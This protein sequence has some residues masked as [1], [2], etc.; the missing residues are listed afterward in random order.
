MRKP[1]FLSTMLLAVW[2]TS[3]CEAPV[4]PAPSTE[5]P[6]AEAPTASPALTASNCTALTT[7]QVSA[8][9]DDGAGSVAANSQDDD[10][11]TRWSGPG[12]GA[13]LTM[14]LGSAQSL[15]GV[16][17]AWHQGTTRQNH[18]TLSTSPDGVTFTQDYAATS[19]LSSAVQ[20]Y[21]FSAPRTGRYVRITVNGNTVNDW[22]SITEA[23]VC[24]VQPVSSVDVGPALPRL[25]YLQSVGP[26]SA[27]VAFRSG[28]S[29]TPYVRFG[30]G[31]D[32]SRTAM[33][34]A[35]GWRHAVKLDNLSPGQTYS[36]SVEACG[37]TT[38]VRQFRTASGAGTSRVHFTAMGDFGTGG[39]L[40]SQVLARMAQGSNA[41]ELILALGD[42]AYSSGTEQEFQDRMFKPMA[43]LLRRVPLF[44][45][46][47]NHEYVT[48]Q[49][50]PYLDNLYMP[51]NN[52]AGSERY[53]SFDWGPVH[54]ISLDSNC[55]IGLASPSRCTLAA[56]KSWV[57]QDLAATGRP[58]KVV[59]FHHP[60][61]S[62]GEHGSQLTMRREFAPLFEQ[63]GVDLVLTG[64]DHN[65]ERSKA[66]KGDG[67][68][69]PGVKGIPYVVVGSG[70]ATLRAFPGAQP[71]WTAYRNNTDAGYLSVV[72]EGGT[73]SAQFINPS[74]TVRDSLSLTKTVPAASALLLSPASSVETPPG[75]VDDP[76]HAPASLRFEH[77]LPPADRPEDVAD[78]G[79]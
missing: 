41:G 60:P 3:A 62:S 47:G 27:L 7:A 31:L 28:V 39:N 46:P 43:A 73:L 10:L 72:V 24:G 70:G 52:P 20:M 9:G 14:D 68:A 26:T 75:P 11:A 35:A 2:L 61:W 66:M 58:W 40:Q 49:A 65:Y 16:A 34:P 78:L 57:A 67:V 79:E 6:A 8:S 18:F 36:Y 21:A 30:P 37:S 64:H 59:F 5:A 19:A 17:V 13:W 4:S 29:C 1:P 15:T 12:Q 71:A 69:A 77:E 25:P 51:A 55:A 32:L 42:N 48:D 56:Q 54:F 45:A 38:G 44:S 22:A 50:Q 76:N 63:Y 53:Y 74:G 33:V 23:R